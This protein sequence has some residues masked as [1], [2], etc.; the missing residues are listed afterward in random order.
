MAGRADL[1]VGGTGCAAGRAGCQLFG[2]IAALEQSEPV[3]SLFEL[4]AGGIG[5]FGTEGATGLA[6]E[7]RIQEEAL[8]AAGAGLEVADSAGG[9]AMAGLAEH[10]SLIVGRGSVARIAE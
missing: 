4:G 3:V 6:Q 2:A 1:G 7:G 10:T 9:A 8:E 5:A